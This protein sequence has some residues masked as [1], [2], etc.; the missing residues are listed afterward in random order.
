VSRKPS[1]RL[2]KLEARQARRWDL[3]RQRQI[4]TLRDHG[5]TAARSPCPTKILDGYAQDHRE[6]PTP[7][8][9]ILKQ[10][11]DETMPR[12]GL[13]FGH[14][15]VIGNRIADFVITAQKLVIEVDGLYHQ[16][17]PQQDHRRTRE[18]VARGYRVIRF[19]NEEVI[20]EPQRVMAEVLRACGSAYE[21]ASDA[22]IPDNLTQL[23]AA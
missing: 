2:A 13:V 7:A 23:T 22:Y 11:L 4:N 21:M 5:V 12:L 17:R 1:R 10:L 14:Q 6:H 20:N 9:A 8:E 3:S 16:F 19:T 18:L 15:V